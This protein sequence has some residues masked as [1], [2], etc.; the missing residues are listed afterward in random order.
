MA[1]SKATTTRVKF[2]PAFVARVIKGEIIGEFGDTESP[3][4]IRSTSTGANYLIMKKSG[5]RVHRIVAR[6]AEGVPVADAAKIWKLADARNWARG[7][8]A[9]LTRGKAPTRSIPVGGV[10]TFA[11]L[12]RELMEGYTLAGRRVPGYKEVA[13]PNSVASRVRGLRDLDPIIGALPV[14]KVDALAAV[15]V[16]DLVQTPATATRAWAAARWVMSA[17]VERGI[18]LANPFARGNVKAPARPADR[19]RAPTLEEIVRIWRAAEEIGGTQGDIT[20][21]IFALPVRA[22]AAS[23][24]VWDDIDLE[25]GTLTIRPEPGSK[26]RRPLV[27]PLVGLARAIIEARRP[28]NPR[29]DSL[30][31]GNSAGKPWASWSPLYRRLHP[32][33]DTSG[34][35]IHDARRSVPTIL[36]NLAIEGVTAWDADSLLGHAVSTSMGS[37]VGAVYNRSDRLESARKAAMAWDAVLAAALGGTVTTLRRAAA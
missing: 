8:V 35:S 23:N 9:D 21:F 7:V 32:M 18:A 30:V 16:R 20:R 2:T 5:G 17:A 3:L 37:S 26:L 6:D 33:S 15:R 19:E 36:G 31:F 34:W 27:M 28:R 13:R 10:A 25:T 22:T 24:L 11:S 1:T 12:A 29:G 14:A 4:R